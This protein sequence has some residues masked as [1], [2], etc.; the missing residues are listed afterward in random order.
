M[1]SLPQPLAQVLERDQQRINAMCQRDSGKLAELLADDLIYIHASSA[2]DDKASLLS[3]LLS[4]AIMYRAI[5]PSEI[6]ARDLGDVILVVGKASI[7]TAAFG[8]RTQ[9]SER[10]SATWV[11]QDGQW[12]MQHWQSTKL[13]E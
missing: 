3:A 11:Q 10:F 4:G 1:D 12:R 13:P 2:K 8:K 6:E 7:T 5:E 9:S